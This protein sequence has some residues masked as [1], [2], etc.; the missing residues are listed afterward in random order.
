M[1]FQLK[2]SMILL[3]LEDMQSNYE[4]KL[5]LSIAKVYETGDS[6]K[7]IKTEFN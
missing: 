6:R 5:K 4:E 7:N 1:S 3:L 2:K